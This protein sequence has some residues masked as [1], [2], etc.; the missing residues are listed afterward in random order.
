MGLIIACIAIATVAT[1]LFGGFVVLLERY[2]QSLK[3]A[4]H[5]TKGDGLDSMQDDNMN[6]VELPCVSKYKLTNDDL[7]HTRKSF[8][9]KTLY[10]ASSCNCPILCELLLDK[11]ADEVDAALEAAIINGHLNICKLLIDNGV[12]NLNKA[13]S[14]AKTLRKKRI[15]KLILNTIQQSKSI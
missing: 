2:L 8:L 12:P 6:Y 1:P 3:S 10:Q 15:E 9:N 7:Q 13:L 4:K 5:K 14:T 11:G